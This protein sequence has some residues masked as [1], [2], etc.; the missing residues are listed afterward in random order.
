MRF[1][2][3][4]GFCCIVRPGPRRASG[5]AEVASG[6]GLALG[7]GIISRHTGVM[8]QVRKG[9]AREPSLAL[10]LLAL[11]ARGVVYGLGASVAAALFAYVVLERGWAGMASALNLPGILLW[12]LAGSLFQG[13]FVAKDVH[14]YNRGRLGL[15]SSSMTWPFAPALVAFIAG[16]TCFVLMWLGTS[17]LA[18]GS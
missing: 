2:P 6:L 13:A 17:L 8:T 1:A 12:V 15:G 16:S 14:V 5:R 9:E 18:A 7:P 10:S 11:L 4:G 3:G